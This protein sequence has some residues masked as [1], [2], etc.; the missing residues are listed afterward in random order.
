MKKINLKKIQKPIK[1][2]QKVYF[3]KRENVFRMSIWYAFWYYIFGMIGAALIDFILFLLRFFL[4]F[5]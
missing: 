3:D 1:I 5:L 2:N 4:I